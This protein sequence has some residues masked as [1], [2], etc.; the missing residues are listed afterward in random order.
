MRPFFSHLLWRWAFRLRKRSFVLPRRSTPWAYLAA[1]FALLGRRK[2][3]LEEKVDR[4]L[5]EVR[6]LKRSNATYMGEGVVLTHLADES[7]IF[8]NANDYGVPMPIL[9]RGTWEPAN[10]EVLFSFLKPHSVVVDVGANLGY[11]ALRLAKR[12]CAPGRVEAFEPH[13]ALCDLLSGS[14]AM[15]GLSALISVHRHGL[16]DRDG[17]ADFCYPKG[18]LGA[19]FVS[20][21]QP[22]EGTLVAGEVRALDNVLAPGTAVDLVKIDVEGHELQVL[23]GMRRVIAESPGIAILLEKLVP[24]AGYE[25]ELA[26]ELEGH[27][28][29]LYAVETTAV[30]RPL[31]LA[32]LKSW[33]GYVLAAYPDRLGPL[34]RSFFAI[35]PAQL[36]LLPA[37]LASSDARECVL[38]GQRGAMLFAGPGWLL[39][40]GLWTL[41]L[42]G[43]L[44]GGIAIAV[45]ERPGTFVLEVT[46][47]SKRKTAAFFVDHDLVGFECVAR[48]VSAG[49]ELR[50]RKIVLARNSERSLFRSVFRKGPA[51]INAL[52]TLLP[53]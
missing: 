20:D 39:E 47:D 22:H 16:S 27:G 50:L 11:F 33:G 36:T 1:A 18:H 43:D 53:R 45:C 40:S 41:E 24:D 34:A 37:S 2:S 51:N 6:V 7:P 14:A 32:E 29:A 42:D 3:R 23:R 48:C 4:L 15:N 49:C 17:P 44:S 30:L 10:T 26:A 12:L 21:G 38:A 35:H 8:V 46:L 28:L 9:T 19:G 5:N 13:P 52:T 31:D 25:P